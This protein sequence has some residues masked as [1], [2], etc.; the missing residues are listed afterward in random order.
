M[1]GARV[2]R[3]GVGIA[4]LVMLAA[5]GGLWALPGLP[6]GLYPEVAFP[7]VVVVATLA[8]ATPAGMMANV[9]RP[10]EDALA[11]VLGVARV[12]SRTIRGGVEISLQFA[13]DVD[14]P[15]ALQLVLARLAEVRGDLPEATQLQAE[16]LTPSS[17][18][19]YSLNVTGNVPSTTLRDV[20]VQQVRPA[21]SRVPGVGP[22]TV[23]GG[24]VRAV[25]VAPDPVRLAAAHL[26]VPTL[27]ERLRADNAIVVAGRVDRDHRRELVV[28][29]GRAADLEEIGREIVGGTP[30]QPVR[31]SNVADILDGAR[32]RVSLVTGPRGPAVA[33]NVARR[34]GGDAVSLDK[35][36][37]EVVERLRKQV[38]PGVV[39][40]PVYRQATLIG[41]ATGSVRDAILLGALLAVLVL[42]FF[43]RD[44]RATLVAALV[45][46]VTLAATLAGMAIVGE[47][48][49]LMSLGGMAI[50]IGLVIDDAVVVVEAI[51]RELERGASPIVA[52][53]RGVDLLAG[54]VV[55]ST[56]TT[57]VVFA[58]L[59][60]L[61]GVAGRFF[62]SL[63]MTLGIAVLVSLILALTAVPLVAS[64]WLRASV[65]PVDKERATIGRAYRRVLER[66]LV[67]RWPVIVAAV[68]LVGAG[69]LAATRV[70]TGFLPELD[71]GSFVLDFHA[72][73]GTAL[74]ETDRMA[75][76]IDAALRATPE[77]STFTRRIGV[78]LGPPA[79]TEM[80]RGDYLVALSRGRARSVDAIMDDLRE[81]LEP[82]LPGVH[83]ELIQVL[84]DM[85]GDLEGNPEP[86]EVKLFASDQPT[87]REAAAKAAAAIHDVPGLVDLFDGQVACAPELTVRVDAL[88]AARAGLTAQAVA[89]Q[90]SGALLGLPSTTVPRGDR[91]IEV[92][93]R[94]P[95]D[96][97]KAPDA[98]ALLR[99]RTSTGSEVPIADVA[100]I[101]R[102]CP[103]SELLREN[104]RLFVGVTARLSGRDL[105]GATSD[106]SDKIAAI[107]FG[108]GVDSEIGGQV[109]SQR[110]SFRSLAEALALAVA[111]V[112]IVMVFQFGAL[113]PALAVLAGAP[114][115]LVG[116]LAALWLTGTPLNVSSFMGGILLIGLAVKN[117]ILLLAEARREEAIGKS[118]REAL[119]HAAETRLRPILMTTLCTML[120]LVPLALGHGTG[121]ELQRPLAIAVLG[122]LALSTIT[123]LLIVPSFYLAFGGRAPVRDEVVESVKG[124]RT[125]D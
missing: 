85:L 69:A 115:A 102:E 44:L 14:M 68:V 35:A 75:G 31:L 88:K 62:S 82:T 116:G 54:P 94:L 2:R 33:V 125:E 91:L 51:H 105:G 36:V 16:R 112:I 50:A 45:L 66:A 4:C 110:A 84:Q 74:E 71:E 38:P 104:G 81:R 57:L 76:K 3:H 65:K 49:N 9:T 5:I 99:M 40:E 123:T 95:D 103:P 56:L 6:R 13:P 120:G 98:L 72:P 20:A 121:A 28:V 61:H 86:V 37:D 12:R 118:R 117:G 109:L 89:D 22:V 80:S 122:G 106:V 17:F 73:I 21:L 97:R 42:L 113:G 90:V 60:R 64:A 96:V 46:P 8:D 15:Q 27:S 79:A 47:S 1:I 26:D 77:V 32:D 70:G 100:T 83:I 108:K 43:L 34:I 48:L 119:G 18:P 7:R 30:E 67:R 78:E 41:A 87:A 19:V 52:A 101:A 53:E 55:S 58:P 111:L 29:T 93:V 25:I 59:G 124:L 107:D 24:D 11:T 92:R 10:L 63:S 39:L 114:F 23:S